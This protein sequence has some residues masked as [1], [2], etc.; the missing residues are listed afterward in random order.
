[1]TNNINNSNSH[2]NNSYYSSTVWQRLVH[3]KSIVVTFDKFCV[4]KP[5][6][7]L[8][9][10]ILMLKNIEKIKCLILTQHIPSL[11]AIVQQC[12]NKIQDEDFSLLMQ[13]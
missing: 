11:Q 6:D 8:L 9:S 3:V 4:S 7:S 2:N 12:G 13:L 1:M 10:N 5:N